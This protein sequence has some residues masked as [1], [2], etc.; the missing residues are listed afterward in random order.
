MHLVHGAFRH[1]HRCVLAARGHRSI[2][3]VMFGDGGQRIGRAEIVALEAMHLGLGDARAQPRI[4]S[5]AFGAAA[6]AR[7]A[8]NIQHWGKGHRQAVRGRL[9]GGLPRR[10]RPQRRIEQRRLAQGYGEQGAVAMNHVE[11]DEQRNAETR[12][13]DRQPLHVPHMM[14]PDHVE[15]IADGAVLDRLRRIP[16]DHRARHRVAGGRHGELAELFSQSHLTQ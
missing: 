5:R 11:S 3:A 15:E 2:C 14:G 12:L 7:I 9:C 8:G 16:R 13:L 1:I 6:P 10:Q 4:L